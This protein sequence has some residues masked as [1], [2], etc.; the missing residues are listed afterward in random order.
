MHN[1]K[2]KF[3]KWFLSK[4]NKKAVCEI[5]ILNLQTLYYMSIIA[6][7]F[8][9]L[10][11]V[12]S[13]FTSPPG[14][15]MLISSIIIIFGIL[16][17]IAGFFIARKF[18]DTGDI[19]KRHKAVNIFV[20]AFYVLLIIWGM[21]ASLPPFIRGEQ[22]ITFFIVEISFVLFVRLRPIVT[23]LIVLLSY[24][25]YDVALS[26]WVKP[27]MINHYNFAML[28][29]VS[30]VGAVIN[31]RLFVIFINEKNN[32]KL[33]N[34]SLEIIANHDSATRLQNR[35]ALNQNIPEY[36]DADICLAMGDIN[37]FKTVNDIYGH[38]TGDEVLKEFSDILMNTF[39]REELYRY[40]GDEFLIVILTGD[41][42]A[43]RKKLVSLNKKFSKINIGDITTP[44]SCSFGSVKAH[45]MNQ[46][47]FLELVSEADKKL[48]EEKERLKNLQ[49]ICINNMDLRKNSH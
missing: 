18:L 35:Y 7:I 20:C 32:E 34:K 16:M 22:I 17:G 27:G 1:L 48:Y 33:I 12:I 10:T 19:A 28:A 49:K 21:F 45:P 47:E 43:F 14:T 31:Y 42:N 29:L 15:D 3:H 11:L 39:G 38:Q 46:A 40:G 44:L 36:I 2:F 5:D 24:L 23:T 13:I 37:N 41:Y 6:I 30:V 25:I 9:I 26:V 4:P 8:H